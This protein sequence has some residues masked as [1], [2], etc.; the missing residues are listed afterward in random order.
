[1]IDD[2]REGV[3]VLAATAGAIGGCVM[4]AVALVGLL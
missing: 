4:I 3:W 1:M 2:A